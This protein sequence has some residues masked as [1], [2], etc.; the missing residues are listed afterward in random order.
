M[1]ARIITSTFSLGLWLGPV[2]TGDD[3]YLRG[4]TVM[5]WGASPAVLHA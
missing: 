3:A 5:Y 4:L 2:P 1:R